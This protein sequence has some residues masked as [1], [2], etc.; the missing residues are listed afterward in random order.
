MVVEQLGDGLTKSKNNNPS[1]LFLFF[2]QPRMETVDVG[3]RLLHLHPHT[4]VDQQ[5]LRML[6]SVGLN[7]CVKSGMRPPQMRDFL[8]V[9][10][11]MPTVIENVGNFAID[12][13]RNP[14]TVKDPCIVVCLFK[15]IGI[16]GYDL[17]DSMLPG[18]PNV[19]ELEER[20]GINASEYAMA[21]CIRN[22]SSCQPSVCQQ[23]G[24][25]HVFATTD[26]RLCGLTNKSSSVPVIVGVAVEKY[27]CVSTLSEDGKRRVANMIYDM[28]TKRG[29]IAGT[30]L[31]K[32]VKA[33]DFD[34]LMYKENDA[35]GFISVTRFDVPCVT[36]WRDGFTEG[37]YIVDGSLKTARFVLNGCV[38]QPQLTE[39]SKKK[40]KGFMAKFRAH[41][42]PFNNLS[43]TTVVVT[44]IPVRLGSN[45]KRRIC[46]KESVARKKLMAESDMWMDPD[47]LLWKALWITITHFK[48]QMLLPLVF[49]AL[50]V[51]NDKVLFQ[52]CGGEDYNGLVHSTTITNAIRCTWHMIDPDLHDRKRMVLQ[53][54][55]KVLRARYLI[56][57]H[58][59][60]LNS[61]QRDEL[62]NARLNSSTD[63]ERA[64]KEFD[65]HQRYFA[66]EVLPYLAPGYDTD[67]EPGI[68]AFLHFLAQS[69]ARATHDK[70]TESVPLWRNKCEKTD[71][72]NLAEQNVYGFYDAITSTITNKMRHA[73]REKMSTMEKLLNK[74]GWNSSRAY[75]DPWT[76]GQATNGINY[77][78]RTGQFFIDKTRKVT[79]VVNLSDSQ[80]DDFAHKFSI[81]SSMVARQEKGGSA[82]SMHTQG[83]HYG[84]I[85]PTKTQEGSPGKVLA[86]AV[87]SRV[88]PDPQPELVGEIYEYL[89]KEPL[90]D[91]FRELNGGDDIG[92]ESMERISRVMCDR[93]R[94]QMVFLDGMVIGMTDSP[95]M[96]RRKIVLRRR[97][98][99]NAW[100]Y[101]SVANYKNAVMI[102][103]KR[104]R[105]GRFA[106]IV[107]NGRIQI[108]PKYRSLLLGSM[109]DLNVLADMDTLV[110]MGAVEWVSSMEQDNVRLMDMMRLCESGKCTCTHADMH[111]S[112]LSSPVVLSLSGLGHA[113][114]PREVFN[115]AHASKGNGIFTDERLFL[116]SKT[117]KSMDMS[118]APID[119]T[120]G[121]TAGP[122]GKNPSA[123]QTFV[124]MAMDPSTQEDARVVSQAAVDR[125]L[126][127]SQKR[128]YYRASGRRMPL[129]GGGDKVG[130]EIIA[131]PWE[132]GDKDL[133]NKVGCQDCID[134][135]QNCP[136]GVSTIPAEVWRW[137][138]EDCDGFV[139][140]G[141]KRGCEVKHEFPGLGRSRNRC[142]DLLDRNDGLPYEGMSVNPAKTESGD[143]SESQHVVIGLVRVMSTTKMDDGSYEVFY[144]DVSVVHRG[145]PA[146]VERV[147]VAQGDDG[148]THVCVTLRAQHV[149]TVGDKTSGCNGQ[150][151]V[152]S[153]KR[154]MEDMLTIARAPPHLQG[155]VPHYIINPHTFVSRMTVWFLM[156]MALGVYAVEMGHRVRATS[157]V[158]QIA[159]RMYNRFRDEPVRYDT[160]RRLMRALSKELGVNPMGEFTMFDPL[161]GRTMG[162]RNSDG[163]ITPTYFYGGHMPMITNPQMM[164]GTKARARGSLGPITN[165]TLEPAEGT[166][167]VR[168]GE[169][170]GW[171]AASHGAASFFSE[172]TCKLSNPFSVHVCEKCHFVLD[173]LPCGTSARVKSQGD[174]LDFVNLKM[175]AELENKADKKACP[176]CN[177]RNSAVVVHTNR[178]WW[179]LTCEM[180]AMGI[181]TQLKT[182]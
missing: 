169:M 11:N 144:K 152:I 79:L 2:K 122:R 58:G 153:E 33:G 137:G 151:G 51:C 96:L 133:P 26:P 25:G 46:L 145:P 156:L 180:R 124:V 47:N 168:F 178:T 99:P 38:N 92:F 48:Q 50:G 3:S 39:S 102:Q 125:G 41:T 147:M 72:D 126:Q 174:S 120:V 70:V 81:V 107:E 160:V 163:T 36:G 139:C 16:V 112:V 95:I 30:Y 80:L 27:K 93:P 100:L 130:D 13:C 43:I 37:S 116:R 165:V 115:G 68:I 106:F 65:L 98:T 103:T 138:C 109:D 9:C 54:E 88:S 56:A 104:N 131:F 159:D 110:E 123:S 173:R 69:V 18:G 129:V 181:Y 31:A 154:P 118:D 76:L 5:E 52:L 28:R 119:H 82:A 136:K 53:K 101:V 7:A 158:N 57:K 108:P 143:A 85:C 166:G 128:F 142:Y 177:A 61:N 23:P 40:C 74:H 179:V 73:L 132:I 176:M 117:D 45:A 97:R 141:C 22:G 135:C 77:F 84:M 114:Y 140:W 64:Q 157:F 94:S 161:L 63:E 55:E 35:D 34:G 8:N 59:L 164:D 170:E 167:A 150:K 149:P 134:V 66:E 17:D 15:Y 21:R 67:N 71:L 83:S 24:M 127:R 49:V 91:S 44:N 19:R 4:P 1:F 20:T 182:C 171:C 172:R 113:P 60:H 146:I 121:N 105:I 29:K 75:Q 42:D 90:F 89:M 111:P 148:L 12:N 87:G 32:R 62:V 155:I 14:S 162:V 78:M 6:H 175:L 10:K 86:F